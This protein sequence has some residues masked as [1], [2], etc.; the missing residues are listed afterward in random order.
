MNGMEDI[1]LRQYET[2]Q[3]T[4]HWRVWYP[5]CNMYD[6]LSHWMSECQDPALSTCRREIL[7]SLP[8][9]EGDKPAHIFTREISL[10]MPQLLID[11]MEP[12][13]LW[14]TNLNT[15][16]RQS[17]LSC[18]PGTLRKIG[19]NAVRSGL[20]SAL[21]TLKRCHKLWV[22]RHAAKKNYHSVRLTGSDEML[23]SSMV[24]TF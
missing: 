9:P 10:L 7:E 3:G 12:E 24:S 19:I 18:L 14:K 2:R 21:E 4:S 23:T 1:A 15:R 17:L 5:L 11:T 22:E 8:M 13:R 6:S 20:C 16:L